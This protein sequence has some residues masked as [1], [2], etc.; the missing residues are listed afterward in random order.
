MTCF[1]SPSTI[2]KTE[3]T[4]I[5]NYV[6]MQSILTVLKI[7]MGVFRLGFLSVY[8]SDQLISG[9]TTGAAF[10]VFTSQINEVFGI[11]KS[12]ASGPGKLFVV[13]NWIKIFL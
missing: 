10:M 9:F 1:A 6:I 3:S 5:L 13:R 7:L 12:H 2:C 11:Q 8:M 4:D